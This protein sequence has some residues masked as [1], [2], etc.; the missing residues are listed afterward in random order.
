MTREEARR[1]L[2][3]AREGED[4]A[5]ALICRALEVTGDIEVIFTPM[6]IVRPAGSW[7]RRN[8]AGAARATW[9]DALH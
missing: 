9:L 4:V 1:L 7:E 6:Q 2:D 8:L 3:R 5:P